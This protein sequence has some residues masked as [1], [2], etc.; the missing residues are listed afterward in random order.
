MVAS[1]LIAKRTLCTFCIINF[2]VIYDIWDFSTNFMEHFIDFRV[3]IVLF[4]Y[5][6]FGNN[7]YCIFNRLIVMGKPV[8]QHFPFCNCIFLADYGQHIWPKHAVENKK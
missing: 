4:Y 8:L 6:S 1:Q 2:K 7:T 5:S 3:F